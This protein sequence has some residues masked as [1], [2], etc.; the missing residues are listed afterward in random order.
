MTDK[1]DIRKLVHTPAEMMTGYMAWAEQ[2]QDNPGIKFG[3]SAIDQKMI[4]MRPGELVCL[5]GRPGDGK[6]SILAYLAKQEADR[7]IARKA[8]KHEAVVYVTWEQSC[9]ELT[10]FFMA[11]DKYSVSDVAWGR[12]DLDTIRKQVV[13]GVHVPIWVIGHGIGRAGEKTPRMTPDAVLEAIE[14]MQADFGIRPTLIL[15][16]YLQLIPIP[17]A[18]ERVQQV[19]EVPIRIKEVALRVGVPAVAGVQASRDVDNRQEKLAEL[20]DAQWASS[21]EQTSDKV[22]SLWRPARTQA[23]GSYIGSTE[24]GHRYEVTDNLLLVRMLK[25]RGDRGRFTWA[26]Y[27]NPAYLK[28]AEMETRQTGGMDYDPYPG[29]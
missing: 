8:A 11:G 25:Q 20:R 10:A 4:P 27:F 29:D 18:R 13:K 21:I 2:A 17:N 1:A 3:V 9:E 7:I 5:M 24:N 19:T 22:F 26:L 14:S 15:F 23:I 16:D 12:V 28:L 6:T